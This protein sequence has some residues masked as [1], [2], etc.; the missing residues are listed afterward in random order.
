MGQMSDAAELC[1]L[2]VASVRF[3]KH[4][5][6]FNIAECLLKKFKIEQECTNKTLDVMQVGTSHDMM[7]LQSELKSCSK[8]PPQSQLSR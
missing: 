8:L 5:Y 7:V 6:I 2:L 1:W 4:F 3:C